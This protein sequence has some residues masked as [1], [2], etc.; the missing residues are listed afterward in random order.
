MAFINMA[1]VLWHFIIMDL[2][3]FS[4]TLYFYAIKNTICEI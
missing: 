4:I 2:A 1:L 3:L